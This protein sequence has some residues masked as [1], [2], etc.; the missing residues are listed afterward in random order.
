MRECLRKFAKAQEEV[1]KKNDFKCGWKDESNSY[2]IDKL[3]D[4]VNE[5]KEV[6]DSSFGDKYHKC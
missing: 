4:K 2:L 1:L 3:I 6:Y 5:L